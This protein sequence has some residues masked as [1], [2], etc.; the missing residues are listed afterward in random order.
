MEIIKF[1][2][3]T[4][5]YFYFSWLQFLGFLIVIKLFYYY[6]FT[7][8]ELLYNY[9][10]N[11]YNKFKN[12]YIGKYVHNYLELTNTK[13]LELR[14]YLINKLFSIIVKIGFMIMFYKEEKQ[15]LK[16][17]K[18]KSTKKFN[19]NKFLNKLEINNTF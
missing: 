12:N 1:C 19:I 17:T 7:F 6:F 2:F 3:I 10:Q 15:I 14:N 4:I 11:G 13:Y 9:I 18:K 16:N 8:Y 5:I